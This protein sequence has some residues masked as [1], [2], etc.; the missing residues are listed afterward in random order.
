MA[1]GF[2]RFQHLQRASLRQPD[3]TDNRFQ[4]LQRVVASKCKLTKIMKPGLK[5]HKVNK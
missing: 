3:L 1:T 5:P 4:H 2:N